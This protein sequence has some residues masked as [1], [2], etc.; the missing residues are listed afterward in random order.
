MMKSPDWASLELNGGILREP[1]GGRLVLWVRA[2][3]AGKFQIWERIATVAGAEGELDQGIYQMPARLLRAR[4]RLG[5]CGL[6]NRFRKTSG[7]QNW[8]LPNGASAEQIEEKKMDVLLVWSQ[9]GHDLDE[10]TIRDRRPCRRVQRLGKN[11]YL[12]EGLA[13]EYEGGE[14][15][16]TPTN[17]RAQAA[18]L[19]AS[20]RV[21]GDRAAEATH[22]ADMGLVALHEGDGGAVALLENALALARQLGD[23]ALEIDILGNLGLAVLT[24][25]S[26]AQ[27]IP[28]FEQVLAHAR[29]NGD[30]FLEKL[31]LERLG[32]ACSS[33]G[34]VEV[35]LAYF[36]Q[37]MQRSRVAGDR[38][39]EAQLLWLVGIQQA[40]LGRSSEAIAAAEAALRL[41]QD[42]GFPQAEMFAEQ[43]QKYRAGTG[44]FA[45][46]AAMGTSGLLGMAFSLAKSMTRFLGS[47]FK[48]VPAHIRQKRLQTCAACVHHTGVRCKLC[49]CF[50]NLK[51]RLPYEDCPIGQ[52]PNFRR[53]NSRR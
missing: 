46:A 24:F 43:L 19:L 25:G 6:L 26:A 32:H 9:S 10:Q 11:I 28:L 33:Q 41:W 30:L 12:L 27:A 18:G 42:L 23:R 29:S 5:L 47:G 1:D 36:E 40:E 31:A 4:Q 52:W 45:A 22:L 3:R 13:R 38:R 48:T 7:D 21:R 20:A 17:L 14:V 37:A 51:S 35:A 53:Q 2:E 44:G 15:E 34:K 49:G 50:T 16:P 39:H 8:L